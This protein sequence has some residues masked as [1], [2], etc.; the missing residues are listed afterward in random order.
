MPSVE[1]KW[2]CVVVNATAHYGKTE[3]VI[4]ELKSVLYPASTQLMVVNNI[5]L[6]KTGEYFIF[7][8]CKSFLK[9]KED[10]LKLA[11][12]L[13]VVTSGNDAYAFSEKELGSFVKSIEKKEKEVKFKKGD[14]V[15]I[16][17]GYLKN[18]FALVCGRKGAEIRVMLKFHVRSFRVNLAPKMLKYEKNI[19]DFMP[20][21]TDRKEWFKKFST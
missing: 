18:L 6:V 9:K 8:S 13:R 4:N 2:Y 12:V 3:A 1:N 15:I 7:V 14:V 11:C 16:K 21:N 5:D 10:I 19:F 17:D 20:S